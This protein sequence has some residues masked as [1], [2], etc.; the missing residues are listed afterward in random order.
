MR[1]IDQGGLFD[2]TIAR[3]ELE[4]RLSSSPILRCCCHGA[5]RSNPFPA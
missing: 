1:T 4:M 5:H 3:D 2:M